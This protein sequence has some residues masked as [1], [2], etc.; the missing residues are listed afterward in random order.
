[1][2]ARKTS[3]ALSPI[4]SKPAFSGPFRFLTG[5]LPPQIGA[6]RCQERHVG[7]F[8]TLVEPFEKQTVPRKFLSACRTV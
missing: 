2:K 4:P 6:A 8:L 1:V 3:Q 5:K 7:D